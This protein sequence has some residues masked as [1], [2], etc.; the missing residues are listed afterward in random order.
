[1]ADGILYT[2]H[3]VYENGMANV[4]NPVVVVAGHIRAA[5]IYNIIFSAMR[6]NFSIA[7]LLP[8]VQVKSRLQFSSFL[9]ETLY[10]LVRI[11]WVFFLFT[12]GAAI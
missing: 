5:H 12:G 7:G 4:V 8:I 1:M 6:Q 10:L 11:L 3:V 2:E 9:Y